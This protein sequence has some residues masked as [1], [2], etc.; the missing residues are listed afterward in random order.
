MSENN[1]PEGETV[2]KEQYNEL[3]EK[4][5]NAT[6]SK[7][8]LVEEIKG[9]RETKQITEAE[10]AELR[11]KLEERSGTQASDE[12]VTPEKIA[13]I[14]SQTVARILSEQDIQTAKANKEMAKAAFLEKYK[15]FAPENDEGGLKFSALENKLARFNLSGLK[16]QN[17]FMSVF[18]DAR[19]LVVER[20]QVNDTGID[21]NPLA[22]SGTG[23]PP[24][25]GGD[26]KLSVKEMQ[27]VERSFGGDKERFLKIKAK[28]PDYVASLLQY[29]L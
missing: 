16:T 6:Q 8:N 27:I 15:E 2:S 21:P 19:N 10:A 3:V 9:L 11:K 23:T 14:T 28:R 13:E 17:D 12:E 24:K 7:V 1:P 22:P 20:S 18:E 26:D 5:A 25:S 29:S 4:L